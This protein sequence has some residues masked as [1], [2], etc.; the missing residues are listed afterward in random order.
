MVSLSPTGAPTALPAHA[1]LLKARRASAGTH[2]RMLAGAR[3]HAHT[4]LLAIVFELPPA[5]AEA[6]ASFLWRCAPSQMDPVRRGRFATATMNDEAY[7]AT[8][9]AAS[10]PESGSQETQDKRVDEFAHRV[11][12]Q[13][14][15]FVGGVSSWWSGFTKQVRVALSATG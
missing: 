9:A 1:V 11:D 4:P 15:Q 7:S 13:V 8:T 5:T 3:T 12:E 10:A 6:H 14:T 2:A